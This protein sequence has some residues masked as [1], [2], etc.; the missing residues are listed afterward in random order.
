M[1]STGGELHEAPVVWR[2]VEPDDDAIDRHVEKMFEGLKQ[3]LQGESER[4]RQEFRAEVAQA[5]RALS[6]RIDETPVGRDGR[7]G[8][9]GEPG[10]D[11]MHIAILPTLDQRRSY[12]CGTVAQWRGGLI[13][14]ARLTDPMRDESSLDAAGWSVILDGESGF[15]ATQTSEREVVF[16]RTLTSG[17]KF[18]T[19]V[20]VPGVVYRG[21]FQKGLVFEAGDACTYG[22]SIWIAS[23]KGMQSPGEDK[24]MWRL[25]VKRGRDGKDAASEE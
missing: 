18:E 7:D 17:R 25:A 5:V 21:V 20:T 6:A 19:R 16:C 9:Q 10:R 8:K 2:R 1:K 13:R 23:R 3:V 24:E 12:A 15:T 4:L 11:A 22:G 14:A